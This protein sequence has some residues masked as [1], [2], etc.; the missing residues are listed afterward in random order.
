[1]APLQDCSAVL[2]A[3][4]GISVVCTLTTSYLFLLRIKA[5][6]HDT[7]PVVIAFVVLWAAVNASNLLVPLSIHSRHIGESQSC[8]ASDMHAR[9]DSFSI[10]HMAYDTLVFICV[11]WK[12]L[13]MQQ[14]CDAQPSLRFNVT[15]QG[16]SH[17]SRVLWS[18]GQLYFL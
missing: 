3:S 7:R 10:L 1:V 11:S 17:V 9:A 13:K 5:L 2:V 12:L 4:A 6:F 15:G 16:M 14:D 18:S 8:I